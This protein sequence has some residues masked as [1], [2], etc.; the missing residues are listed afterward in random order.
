M[1]NKTVCSPGG[2]AWWGDSP[3]LNSDMQCEWPSGCATPMSIQLFTTSSGPIHLCKSNAFLSLPLHNCLQ[4]ASRWVASLEQSRIC[5]Q[6]VMPLRATAQAHE[7]SSMVTVLSL[8]KMI[9][10][11]TTNRSDQASFPKYVRKVTDRLS[12]RTFNTRDCIVQ[13]HKRCLEIKFNRTP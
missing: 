3:F 10:T 2:K 12:Q 6:I 9:E 8:L 13:Q 7:Q 11:T 4:A 5:T 1:L